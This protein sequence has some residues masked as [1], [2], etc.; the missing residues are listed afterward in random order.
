MYTLFLCNFI[1][2]LHHVLNSNFNL[3][4]KAERLQRNKIKKKEEENEGLIFAMPG[5]AIINLRKQSKI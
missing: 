2:N 4:L 3:L 1:N 5:M